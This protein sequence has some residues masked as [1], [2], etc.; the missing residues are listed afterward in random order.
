MAREHEHDR[1]PQA[2]PPAV[3][4]PA[5]ADAQHV[6]Q[7]A[8]PVPAPA[9]AP[10]AGAPARTASELAYE[11]PE[12]DPTAEAMGNAMIKRMNQANG[13]DGGKYDLEHGIHYSY[14]FEREC[15]QAGKPELWKDEYRYGYNASG[16]WQ[17][18]QETGGFMD[19]RLKKG[20]SAS[21]AIQA[22]LGGLTVAECLTA[23]I[24]MQ[25]DTV[26]RAVGDHKFDKMFGSADAQEDKAVASSKRLRIGIGGT[27]MDQL[28]DATE[29]ARLG[30]SRD[31]KVGV[32]SDEE[33]DK[34]LK[35]GEWYYF[36]NHPKYLLKHPGGAWQGENSLYM[37]KN[38]AG[39]RLWSGMGASNKTEDAMIDEMVLAYNGR[40]DKEDERE[41]KERGITNADGTYA[42]KKYDP[43][44][45]EF[46]D[47]VT[48]DDIL[49][50]PA[51][52]IDGVTRKGGF[53]PVAG[54]TFDFDRV[55]EAREKP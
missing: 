43:A 28:T 35:P 23:V 22:W 27:P 36:Y 55:K 7:A 38:A 20:H 16:H 13:L 48:R 18:P 15:K 46:K 39:E 51:Y 37:G 26:R 24:A 1:P 50:D 54:I 41:M 33:K 47:R 21:K 44:G 40:R 42:D 45:G 34:L 19:F 30:H 6:A 2:A 9:A 49:K 17:N 53:L 52:E 4:T 29:L 14:N 31:P 3:D 11:T 12:I 5:V 10:Q 8:G 32:V 25:F